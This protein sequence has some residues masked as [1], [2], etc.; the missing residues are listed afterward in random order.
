MVPSRRLAF[1]WLAEKHVSLEVTAVTV[2]VVF[3]YAEQ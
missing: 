1:A 3:C 2:K